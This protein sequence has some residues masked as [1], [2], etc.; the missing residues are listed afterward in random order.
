[1]PLDAFGSRYTVVDAA[2]HVGWRFVEL[3]VQLENMF[4]NRYNQ[5]EL[6]YASNFEAPSARPSMLPQLHFAAGPPLSV[7][8]T[9]T[10][11]W[12]RRAKTEREAERRAR[13][14]PPRRKRAPPGRK[15][16]RR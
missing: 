7:M 14:A 11:H 8:G 1:L 13:L 15:K 10:L 12:D 5:F 9:L 4:D 6:Y 2:G 16:V 3:G